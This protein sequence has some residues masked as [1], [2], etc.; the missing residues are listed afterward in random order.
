[1]GELVCTH[2]IGGGVNYDVRVLVQT[3]S[4]VVDHGPWV[5]NTRRI[6]FLTYSIKV[7]H[8]K[9][10]IVHIPADGIVFQCSS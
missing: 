6:F 8:T 4:I 5:T 9:T 10:E 7:Q 3:T 2:G 1:M